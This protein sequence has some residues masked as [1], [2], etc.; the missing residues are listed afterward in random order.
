MA[1][2]K[3]PI[4]VIWGDMELKLI[5]D[6]VM[7]VQKYDITVDREELFKALEYDRHSYEEGFRRGYQ[8]A[9]DQVQRALSA[10]SAYDALENDDWREKHN[11]K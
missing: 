4:E 9:V 2:Y 6:I 10:C 5:D 1:A 11:G 3:S 8:T 7:A